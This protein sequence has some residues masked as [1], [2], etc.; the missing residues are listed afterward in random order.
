MTSSRNV[1]YWR[2]GRRLGSATLLMA[3]VAFGNGWSPYLSAARE[4]RVQAEETMTL[5]R[6]AKATPVPGRFSFQRLAA[7]YLPAVLD[8][9]W[10][11]KIDGSA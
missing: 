3:V 6:T 9:D 1:G 5:D 4:L 2:L 10:P 11:V 7:S 8:G